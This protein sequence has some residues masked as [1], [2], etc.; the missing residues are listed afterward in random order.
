MGTH[1]GDVSLAGSRAVDWV[2]AGVVCCRCS[3]LSWSTQPRSECRAGWGGCAV[4]L[5]QMQGLVLLAASPQSKHT[6]QLPGQPQAR[7]QPLVTGPV[8]HLSAQPSMRPTQPRFH[9]YSSG[10]PPRAPTQLP[11]ASN[12]LICLLP[13]HGFLVTPESLGLL[14]SSGSTRPSG[15]R[16]HCRQGPWGPRV[17]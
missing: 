12:P 6:P 16:W 17:R 15:R 11:P 3:F 1:P 9:H 10:L 14:G 13:L 7:R 5:T 4:H 8:P 2:W